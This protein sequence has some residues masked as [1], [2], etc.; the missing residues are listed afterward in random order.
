MDMFAIIAIVLTILNIKG[1]AHTNW[2]V[3][4]F[5][6]AL[7]FV[8]YACKSN[9]KNKKHNIKFDYEDYGS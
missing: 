6:A 8:V 3:I 2:I 1:V 5:F 9:R 7:S 4:I